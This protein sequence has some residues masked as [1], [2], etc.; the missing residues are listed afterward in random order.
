RPKWMWLRS[1]A[2]EGLTVKHSSCLIAIV[3]AIGLC[4]QSPPTAADRVTIQ[5][6][7][8]EAIERNLNLLAERY[9]IS[10]ADARI[11][12]ARLRQNPVLS[13]GVDYI[14]FLGEFSPDKNV[15]PSEW[16][17]RTDFVLERGG[18]RA[19]RIEVATAQKEVAQL[20]LLNTT[21]LL[22]LDVQSAFI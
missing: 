16:N 20:Q 19:R 11:I 4:A 10:V 17:V 7:V 1:H 12:T 3:S 9:N 13:L 22:V 6:A 5:Q 21:R 14:D 8:Q 2:E 18:K 15:G